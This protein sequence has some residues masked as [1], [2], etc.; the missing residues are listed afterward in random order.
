MSISQWWKVIAFFSVLIVVDFILVGC[1]K[2][3]P[4]QQSAPVVQ[5]AQTPPA[6][7]AQLEFSDEPPP[8]A[9]GVPSAQE[10][11]LASSVLSHK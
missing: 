3:E 1:Q 8:L 7:V 9:Q 5:Q 10:E 2:Q 4:K 11:P 6:Q